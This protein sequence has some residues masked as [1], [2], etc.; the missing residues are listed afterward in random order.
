MQDVIRRDRFYKL[1]VYS[2]G[3]LPCWKSILLYC[4]QV[5]RVSEERQC[6][7]LMF[8]FVPTY[9]CDRMLE[10]NWNIGSTYRIY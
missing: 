1:G 8:H 4:V 2:H 7:L 3:V 10:I 9:L 5:N 6:F